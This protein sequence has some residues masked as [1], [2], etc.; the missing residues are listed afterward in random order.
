MAEI[1]NYTFHPHP[2]RRGM[3]TL[4][5]R[6]TDAAS[7]CEPSA[8][9]SAVYLRSALDMGAMRNGSAVVAGRQGGSLLM[10]KQVAC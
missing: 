4:H 5:R 10:P 3:N 2:L 7:A 8:T 9:C 1:L 6:M